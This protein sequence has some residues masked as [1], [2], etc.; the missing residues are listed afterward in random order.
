MKLTKITLAENEN[1]YK[2]SSCTAYII[3]DDV[4]ENKEVLKKYEEVREGIK[5]EI[6]T[7]NGGKKIEYRKKILKN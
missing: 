5:K 7:I 2:F 4:D 6:K 3:L 1:N